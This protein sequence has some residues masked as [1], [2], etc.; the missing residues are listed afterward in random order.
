MMATKTRKADPG[1]ASKEVEGGVGN[2]AE[3]AHDAG[4]ALRLAADSVHRIAELLS[5]CE[6]SP[7]SD[8]VRSEL[9]M[10]VGPRPGGIN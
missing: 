10:L 9:T 1:A 5:N 4:R 7:M 3:E 2:V 6:V 8:D